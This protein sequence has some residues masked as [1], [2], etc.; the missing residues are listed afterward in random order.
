MDLDKIFLKTLEFKKTS[1]GRLVSMQKRFFDEWAQEKL[2]SNGFKD[3]KMSYFAILMNISLEGV[4]STELAEKICVTK[5]A[6]SKV[7]KELERQGL[8]HL[9]TDEKDSRRVLI[10]LTKRGKELVIQATENVKKKT[11][12]YEKLVGKEKFAEA[13]ET[14]YKIMEHDREEWLRRR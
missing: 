14:M 3:F 12:E 7:I 6:S 5:Q 8:V 1:Y 9:A 4:T 11:K 13:M 2:E 10:F